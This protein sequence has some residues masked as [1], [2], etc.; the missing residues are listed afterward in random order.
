MDIAL[1]WRGDTRIPVMDERTR[2][3]D[4]AQAQSQALGRVAT[5]L[6]F[7]RCWQYGLLREF[8]RK[9]IILSNQGRKDTEVFHL[10]HVD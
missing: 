5:V 4:S 6:I 10:R 3:R 8:R 2:G 1:S 9:E 7:Y